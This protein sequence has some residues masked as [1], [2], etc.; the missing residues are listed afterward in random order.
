M[1]SFAKLRRFQ[2]ELQ[3]QTKQKPTETEQIKINIH[4]FA[5]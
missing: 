3:A 5:L 1:I 4:I 2:Q